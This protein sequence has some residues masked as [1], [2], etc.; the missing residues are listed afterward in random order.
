ML[1][2]DQA[3]NTTGS[4]VYE[5]FQR[6]G[7]GLYIPLYQ[8]EYSWD[9]DNIEQLLDDI[10]RGIERLAEGGNEDEI[11][12]LGTIISVAEKDKNKIEPVDKRGLPSAIE[13]IID[14]QQRLSTICL[15][16]T[17]L[18]K[19]I[20]DF[21]RKFSVKSDLSNEINEICKSWKDKL[22][23]VISLDLKR[24]TP[25]RKPKIIRGH[26]DKWIKDG[27]LNDAYKSDLANFLALFINYVEFSDSELP[28]PNKSNVGKN[29]KQI[30]KWLET[31]VIVAHVKKS[32]E[33]PAAWDLLESI[34]ESNIWQYERPGL[35]D[36]VVNKEYDDKK[37]DEYI[38]CA[39]VQLFSVC[40]YLLSR[41]CFTLIQPSNDDWA[42]DMFQSL[43]ASGTPL[44]AIETFKPLVVNTAKIEKPKTPFKGS[45]VDLSFEKID[46]L[47][48]DINSAAQKSKLTNDFLISLAIVIE[49]YKLTSHF[50]HQRKW[51]DR[52][53]ESFD[54]FAKKTDYLEF[55]GNYA[56]FYKDIWIDYKGTNNE[57]IQTIKTNRDAELAS[58]I[59]L[60][61]KKSNHKM[62]VTI[63]GSFYNE[64]L[65]GSPNSIKNFIE[66]AKALAAFY[67]LWRAAQSN[68]G[69]DNVYRQYFKGEKNKGVKVKSHS[70]LSGEHLEVEGLKTY[71]TEILKSHNIYEKKDWINKSSNYLTYKSKSII[72]F[73]LILSAHDTIADNDFKGLMKPSTQG[74]SS[75]L[76]LEK[77]NSKGVASIEHIAPQTQN[78]SWD[79]KLYDEDKLYQSI[80]NLTLLP[81]A[82]NS[83]AGN[84]GWKEKLLY[85][86]HLSEQDPDKLQ[87]LKI[88]A[89]TNG[90]E[91]NPE[92]I[93][94]LQSTN[95]NDHIRS[96]VTLSESDSWDSKIVEQR[97]QR[98]LS[99]CW[100]RLI[101][102]I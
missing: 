71:L 34:D 98:I 18:Y 101:K 87:E 82:I 78:N 52:I 57:V 99:I 11:R 15:L 85:Y 27:D 88:K 36:L 48:S 102:W 80:G 31:E 54:D 95:Y 39:L 60:Y 23:D 29:T 69:L 90:I 64:V 47:F 10:S 19:H 86:K 44:T 94:L 92:T 37:S 2:I 24:G 16:A 72:R 83:S 93:K 49:S 62:A 50:S 46:N 70:W 45:K 14:G 1:E 5:F 68:S 4:S 33:F 74:V 35:K 89:Q 26:D 12:F 25:E 77:W 67:T 63:L 81:T 84:K 17:Q 38:I 20:D 30:N 32:D 96:L 76:N 65:Q 9:K 79:E 97:T 6:P 8:R 13:K 28:K 22:L 66:A 43:N 91:L 56:S 59:I 73:L 55:V 53:F 51:L 21:N 58:I 3:F 40:H 61:F 42:F 41:C 100:D 75:Y 7:I